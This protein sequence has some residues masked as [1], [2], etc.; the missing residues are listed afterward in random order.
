MTS[1][2]LKENFPAEQSCRL[3]ISLW[4]L[5]C[6][7]CKQRCPKNKERASKWARMARTDGQMEGGI[8]LLIRDL[9]K[10]LGSSATDP[11]P[12][13]LLSLGD[14]PPHHERASFC[15]IC[16]REPWLEGHR[17]R[18]LATSQ[19]T[20]SATGWNCWKFC[21]ICAETAAT[22]PTKVWVVIRFENKYLKKYINYI[23]FYLNA[24]RYPDLFLFSN[25]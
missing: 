22:S 5:Q 19:G 12:R 14:P 20:D 23:P 25:C 2:T 9:I 21:F 10:P 6:P 7:H 4:E 11:Q 24:E 13:T 3:E 8:N 1:K 16:N 17:N 18:E 15:D